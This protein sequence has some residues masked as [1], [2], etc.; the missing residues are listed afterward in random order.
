MCFISNMQQLLVLMTVYKPKEANKRELKVKFVSVNLDILR[1]TLS[2][3]PNT[4][5]HTHTHTL[6]L[7]LHSVTL[8]SWHLTRLPQ[9][10]QICIVVCLKSLITLKY[11]VFSALSR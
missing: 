1:Y 6:S 5:T 9:E 4:H 10:L 8:Y 2:N 3:L 11:L 7:S